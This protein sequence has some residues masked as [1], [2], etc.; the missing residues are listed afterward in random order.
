MEK[1]TVEQIKEKAHSIRVNIIKSLVQAKSGHSAGPLGMADILATLYFNEMYHD[2]K[3]PDFKDRDYFLLSCGHTAPGVYATLAEAGY[4][5]KK[6]LNTLRKYGTKLQGHPCR[7]DTPGIETSSGS[8]GQGASI[9]VG[10][11]YGLRMDKRKNRVYLFMSDGEQEEGSTWEAAMF[12]GVNKLDNVCGMIDYNHI[13]IEG[14]VEDIMDIGPLKEKYEAFRWHVIEVD[15]NDVDALLK[16]F[17]EA[18]ETKGKPTVLICT[19]VPGKGVSFMEGKY[20]WHGK[21]PKEDEAK[22]ALEELGDK[23]NGFQIS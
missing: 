11:A 19:T 14:D 15:G 23:E 1:L 3:K 5:P 10:L 9:A 8:L 13:Q 18:R 21:P 12:A 17:K 22:E 7:H 20:G 4:F 2:P 6:W 16:A